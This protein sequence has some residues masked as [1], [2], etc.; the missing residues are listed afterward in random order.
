MV[1]TDVL[2]II[3]VT[4]TTGPN[5]FLNRIYFYSH[6]F[7][8]SWNPKFHEFFNLPKLA[9]LFFFVKIIWNY[10]LTGNRRATNTCFR[11]YKTRE[12]TAS[13]MLLDFKVFLWNCKHIEVF[14]F[15]QNMISE[16]IC[17]HFAMVIAFLP[18]FFCT[19]LTGRCLKGIFM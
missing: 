10:F 2:A 17:L 12:I 18:T 6:F 8:K 1:N 16:Y 14:W 5:P 7:T 13:I 15:D 4:A 19:F 11:N 9:S 3:L